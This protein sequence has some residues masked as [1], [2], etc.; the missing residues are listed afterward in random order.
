VISSGC[1]AQLTRDR[2]RVRARAR[3]GARARVR[4]RG[5]VRARARARAKVGVKG[6]LRVG[7]SARALLSHCRE[8]RLVVAEEQP[9][10]G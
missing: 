10:I 7:T 8:V 6:G 2:V 5:R 3:V 1:R 9:W 4:V